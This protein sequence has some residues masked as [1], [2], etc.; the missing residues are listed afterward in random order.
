MNAAVAF[1]RAIENLEATYRAVGLRGEGAV[2]ERY[3][4]GFACMSDLPHAVSNYAILSSANEPLAKHLAAAAR[5]RKA[6]NVYVKPGDG[7]TATVRVLER[8]GFREAGRLALLFREVSP[9]DAKS[10]TDPQR[11]LFRVERPGE[12]GVVEAGS[13]EERLQICRFM[14]AQFFGRQTSTLR[15]SIAVATAGAPVDLYRFAGPRI[16]AAAMGVRTEGQLGIYNLCVDSSLRERGYG[17][18]LLERMVQ[19]AR[20]EGRNLN[21]QCDPSLEPWYEKRG[22]G[23]QGTILV[24]GLERKPHHAI[25]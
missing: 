1:G 11:A 14:A 13:F 3:E 6:F 2:E 20:E 22:F 21:L 23:S 9:S 8:A 16:L 19:Y 15:E 5:K 4:T 7:F 12:L 18:Q 25:M 24:M 17:S 10:S